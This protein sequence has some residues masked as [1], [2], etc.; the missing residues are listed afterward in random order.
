MVTTYEN[1]DPTAHI[2]LIL[3]PRRCWLLIR[4]LLCKILGF[5]GGDYEEFRLLGCYALWLL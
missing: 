2:C 1:N 3:G 5:H 4:A